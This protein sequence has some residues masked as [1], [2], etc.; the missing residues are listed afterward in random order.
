M[1]DCEQSTNAETTIKTP[2]IVPK[3]TNHKKR[4][5]LGK[6]KK[7]GKGIKDKL[8]TVSEERV[9][10]PITSFSIDDFFCKICFDF[11]AKPKNCAKCKNPFCKKCLQIWLGR[12]A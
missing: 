7:H 2:T 3:S 1:D 4:F 8:M 12:K 5:R 11:V 10:F 9:V 6:K